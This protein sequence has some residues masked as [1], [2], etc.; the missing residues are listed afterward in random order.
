MAFPISVV[1]KGL[2][3]FDD[4]DKDFFLELLP[5]PRDQDRLPESVRFWK[6]RIEERDQTTFT[7]GVIYGPSGCGKSSL[8]KAGLLPR[9]SNRILPVY[10]EATADDTENRLLARLHKRCPLLQAD[11]DLTQTILALRQGDGLGQDEKVLIVLDQFEQWLHAKSGKRTSKLEKALRQ[12]DGERVQVIALVRDD[13]WLAMSRFMGNLKI[14]LVQGQNFALVDLFDIGHAKHVLSA[15]GRAFG[16][17]SDPASK[18]QEAFLEQAVNGL[19]QDGR[20]ISVRLALFAEMVK[21]KIWTPATLREVGGTE[22]VGVTFLEET[23][24]SSFASPK[25][26]LH[27]DAVRCVL[28][29]LLPEQGSDIKGKKQAHSKLLEAS[30]YANRPDDFEELLHLLNSELKL[31]TGTDADDSTSQYDADKKYY[32]LTHD[33]LVHSLRNWLTRKQKETRRGRAELLL[34]DRAA[35]WNA[36]PENRQLP[37]LLQCFQI[38]WLTDQR[39]WTQQQRKLMREAGQYHSLLVLATVVVGALVS[40]AGY[41]IHGKFE[42]HALRDRLLDAKT[43]DLPII[44]KDMKYYRSWLDGPLRDAMHEP[45]MAKDTDKQ[46]HISLALLP[47]DA[48]QVEYLFGRLLEAQ[49]NQVS[50]IRDALL[51]HKNHLLQKLWAVVETSEKGKEKQ[52]LRAASAL[53]LYDQSNTKWQ[54]CS[55]FV[56]DDLVLENPIFLGQ[57]S[58]MFWPVKGSFLQP[59]S[60]IFRDQRLEHTAERNLA[61]NLLSDYAADNPKVLADLLMDADEKQFAVIF[62]TF[63]QSSEQGLPMLIDLIDRK[64]PSETNDDARETL[65]KRQANAAVALLR[66]NQPAKVWPIFKF[67]PK[68]NPDPKSAQLSDSSAGSV[69]C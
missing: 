44:V 27:Q 50:V 43:E 20:V 2:R 32:Q 48:G 5:G 22:G 21:G 63:Q 40:W 8:V 12:C 9:L 37:S 31:I 45:E 1:P 56:V 53:A 26:R 68:D 14:K 65:A 54:T 13:F 33:Y 59:L 52:R 11:L 25:N 23:F 41:H 7:V 46:L 3:S 18:E 24:C 15:F 61:T 60:E 28:N 35:V 67:A 30:G 47:V 62:P 51:P 16:R 39:N 38:A 6:H 58:E 55:F 34:A 4:Q 17:I 57:W 64:L 69:G 19:A 29:A 42:A 66:L 49:P 36:R 10:V